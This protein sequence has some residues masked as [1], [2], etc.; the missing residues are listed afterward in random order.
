RGTFP[1]CRV[2]PRHVECGHHGPLSLTARLWEA[3][4]S[5]DPIDPA[6][7]RDLSLALVHD[8][9]SAELH[10]ALGLATALRLRAPTASLPE[11]ARTVA[12]YF[13]RAKDCD[14]NLIMAGLNLAECFA[15]AGK[16]DAAVP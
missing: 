6:L 3:L 12:P 15:L 10:N 4:S 14:A 11:I 7:T 1:T 16:P 2:D 8:P 13:G 9:H 5:S